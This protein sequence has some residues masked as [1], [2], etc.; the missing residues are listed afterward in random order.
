MS[1]NQYDALFQ[2]AGQ[3]HNV[4]PDLLRAMAQQESGFNP[5]AVSPKG[6]VGILQL[7]PDTA[8]DMGVVDRTDPAQ[9]IFG[10]ARYMS[11]LIG[12]YG[13]VDKA[14]QAYNMGPAAFDKYQ[15]GQGKTLPNET[16]QYLSRVSANFNR[17]KSNAGFVPAQDSASVASDDPI[18]A[19]LSGKANSGNPAALDTQDDPIVAALSGK[20]IQALAPKADQQPLV[21]KAPDNLR[22]SAN[23]AN[24]AIAGIPDALL[25][26]PNRVLNLGKAF[27]GTVTT[28]MGRPDLAPAVTEDPNFVR[29][30]FERI[31]FIKPELDPQTAGQRVLSNV[32]QGAVGGAVNPANGL[33]QAATNAVVGGLSGAAAGTTK[34]ITGND[35]LA[36]TAGMLAPAVASKVINSAQQGIA[37]NQ[38]RQQQNAA[39]DET[40]AASR[41]AGYVVSPSEIN[42]SK[43]N[44]AIE[45]VAGKLSTR[46]LASSKN[47]DVTNRLVREELGVPENAPLTPEL[48]SQIRRDAYQEG[49]APVASAGPIR[50][51]AAY[52]RDLDTIAQQYKGAAR[53]FPGAVSDEVGNMI[54]SLKVKQFDAADGVKMAQVLRDQSSKSYANGDKAMGKAQRAAATAIEDQIERG[55]TGLGKPGADMLDNFRMARQLMAKTHSVEAAIN[56]AT[57]NVEALKL[58]AQLRKGR[59]LSGNLETVG[60]AAA[61]FPKNF[62]SMEKVGAIPGFSPLDMFGSAGLGA[63]GASATGPGG[64]LLAALP[65]V[66]PAA[67]SVA[68][69]PQYQKLFANPD[70]SNSLTRQAIASGDLKNPKLLAAILAMQQA[71]GQNK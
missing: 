3:Q 66:R 53:S 4:D 63:L 28:A 33:R 56:P 27:V 45:G 13:D 19:A 39:R 23:A 17:I 36:M 18:I 54:D 61:A 65:A 10:G 16:A 29:K 47:Q 26:T 48:M 59:P 5:A 41:D 9:N 7:M 31:G 42:P 69:S 12:K 24:R 25:N 62:Q 64:A 2:Q 50:P 57:G 67:R 52:K 35:T 11:Q 8:K 37:N 22:M 32:V 60:S 70:Y 38:L 68:L 6:A 34:E 43:I 1:A 49:Y 15:S 58:A 40:I 46:Q 14:V 20:G 30:G 71:Q 51:G 21:Q 55:L 44:R